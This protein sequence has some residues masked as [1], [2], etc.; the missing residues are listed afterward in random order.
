M[1]ANAPF[2]L[3][4]DAELLW[5]YRQCLHVLQYLPSIRGQVL[6]LIIDRCL[7]VD[8]EIKIT[9]VGEATIDAE[10][11]DDANVFSLDLEEHDGDTEKTE[12]SPT[13]AATTKK[14]VEDLSVDAMAEKL[15]SLMLVLFEHLEECVA[16]GIS[17]EELFQI[18]LQ[19]FESSI[20]ITHKSKFVQFLILHVCGLETTKQG[21]SS[22]NDPEQ[23]ESV[24]Y[25]EFAARLIDIVLDPYRATVTRQ[26]GACYLASF[27][28][29]AH[30]VCAET[31]R[32]SV[33]ALLRWAEA[34]VASLSCA[35]P[36]H[37]ADAR[38][39][40]R[41]HSLF[42][43]VCQSAFYI[44]CFRGSDA[45]YLGHRDTTTANDDT[46]AAPSDAA[47]G[48]DLGADRWT[49][50][51]A[52]PL[53]PL[54]YCL[55]SVRLEFLR[56]SKMFSLLE[57]KTL[58]QLLEDD[59]HQ[60][61]SRSQRNK[62]RCSV[63]STAVTLEK[64]RQR[65]GVGGIGR[66]TNPLDSFFPFDPYLLRRSHGFIEPFYNHWAGGA[67]DVLEK[68]DLG[69][70]NANGL[71]VYDEEDDDDDDDDGDENDQAEKDTA[72]ENE[73]SDSDSEDE[74]E[75][76]TRRNRLLSFASNA[77]SVSSF[78]GSVDERSMPQS[79]ARQ[80]EQNITR[81]NSL[82]RARAPSIE[83]NGSW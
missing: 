53:L 10:E 73:D 68:G 18:L 15:D 33:D 74:S 23:Q 22:L 3:R 9:D 34:Y 83:S 29:R 14:N 76:F 75:S 16:N 27:V 65:G 39:Q 47:V 4:P 66:G 56:I 54:R 5:Y 69:D 19:I 37:A 41:R 48:V 6:E 25:R 1:S 28:S 11:E 71:L 46:T 61:G 59:R 35:V 60:S 51:C 67:D 32:E 55:E 57:D 7:E 8:V 52:H 49:K 70:E 81:S 80:G 30:F 36:L 77:T 50:I 43:T 26:T 13:E 38:E 63:I 24:L 40:S 42:Y 31:V 17:T 79:A 82:K 64:E 78:P 44:M 45:V 12:S 20:I 58:N 62:K 2:R 72:D 21:Q